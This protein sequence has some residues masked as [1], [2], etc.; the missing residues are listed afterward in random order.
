M[1]LCAK[2]LN[3]VIKI[4]GFA[5]CAGNFVLLPDGLS[6]MA[7]NSCSFSVLCTNSNSGEKVDPSAGESG[8]PAASNCTLCLSVCLCVCLSAL[9]RKQMLENNFP[10]NDLQH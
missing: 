6:D 7:V 2:K 10:L 4:R 8:S 3:S 9:I 5:F 1:G